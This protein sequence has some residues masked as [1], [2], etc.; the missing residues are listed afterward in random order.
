MA[1]IPTNNVP[2]IYV[3]SLSVPKLNVPKLYVPRMETPGKGTYKKAERKHVKD[4]GDI[5]LGDPIRGTK[6]LK[7]TLQD[8]GYGFYREVPFI[9]RILGLQLLWKERFFEPMSEGEYW[10]AAIN[11]LETLGSSLDI[12]ANP[13]KS[14]MPWAGGGSGEDFLR[15]IGLM[16]GEYRETYQWDTGNGV[17]DF[18]GEVFSDPVNI[19]TFGANSVIKSIVKNPDDIAKTILKDIPDDIVRET[20][21]QTTKNVVKTALRN[22]AELNEE[23]LR[24]YYKHSQSQYDELYNILKGELGDNRKLVQALKQNRISLTP[25]IIKASPKT[26]AAYLMRRAEVEDLTRIFRMTKDLNKR[27][28]ILQAFTNMK[29]SKAYNTLQAWRKIYAGAKEFDEGLLKLA[30]LTTPPIGLVAMIYKVGL[31]PIFQAVWN[32]YTRKLKEVNLKNVLDIQEV[33]DVAT[34]ELE[35]SVNAAYLQTT[36]DW[37]EFFKK[38]NKNIDLQTL[39]KMYREVLLDTSDASFNPALIERKFLI[40]VFDAV[41]ELKYVQDAPAMFRK[42]LK[43]VDYGQI[44]NWKHLKIKDLVKYLDTIETGVAASKLVSKEIYKDGVMRRLYDYMLDIE[45]KA[46]DK[47]ALSLLDADPTTNYYTQSVEDIVLKEEARDEAMQAATAE[48]RK[49]AAMANSY[50]ELKLEDYN[51]EVVLNFL[52]DTVFAGNLNDIVGYLN[53][54][55]SVDYQQYITLLQVLEPL[56]IRLS[57]LD[58]IAPLIKKARVSKNPKAIEKLWAIMIDAAREEPLSE[59][60]AKIA[61]S[62]N[63]R[64]NTKVLRTRDTQQE[65]MKYLEELS[66]SVEDGFRLIDTKV[67]TP[68]NDTGLPP[69]KVFDQDRRR[70]QL[71]K[72]NRPVVLKTENDYDI[73]LTELQEALTRVDSSLRLSDVEAAILSK[74]QTTLDKMAETGVTNLGYGSIDTLDK[75]I[76]VVK[77]ATEIEPKYPTIIE[78]KKLPETDT[79]YAREIIVQ[80]DMTLPEVLA[81]N[82]VQANQV[83]YKGYKET[84]LEELDS[85]FQS[86]TRPFMELLNKSHHITDFYPETMSPSEMLYDF[87][88][89]LKHLQNILSDEF[90]IEDMDKVLL[91]VENFTYYLNNLQTQVD[92]WLNTIKLERIETNGMSVKYSENLRSYLEELQDTLNSYQLLELDKIAQ[93]DFKVMLQSMQD[94]NT[95]LYVLKRNN[96]WQDSFVLDTLDKQLIDNNIYQALKNRNSDLRKNLHHIILQLKNE[97]SI[98]AHLNNLKEVLSTLDAESV[99]G[100][101]LAQLEDTSYV[102]PLQDWI[103]GMFHNVLYKHYNEKITT[104]N[105]EELL[106]VLMDD[107]DTQLNSYGIKSI[108]LKDRKSSFEDLIKKVYSDEAAKYGIYVRFTDAQKEML[109]Q[110]AKE[111]YELQ[112]EFYQQ[113][114]KEKHEEGIWYIEDTIDRISETMRASLLGYLEDMQSVAAENGLKVIS[115]YKSISSNKVTKYMEDLSNGYNKIMEAVLNNKTLMQKNVRVQNIFDISHTIT[116]MS[117]EGINKEAI[118]PLLEK[119][120]SRKQF[121]EN[122]DNLIYLKGSTIRAE[123]EQTFSMVNLENKFLKGATTHEGDMGILATIS[124]ADGKQLRIENMLG[125]MYG[126]QITAL[127][128]SFSDFLNM[129]DFSTATT[130]G[131][132]KVYSIEAMRAFKIYVNNFLP[133]TDGVELAK[134]LKLA[135]RYVEYKP[136]INKTTDQ[137]DR[138]RTNLKQLTQ[139]F[140]K[141][142]QTAVIFKDAAFFDRADPAELYFWDD[143]YSNKSVNKEIA[144]RY[145]GIKKENNYHEFYRKKKSY[146][147]KADYHA[148]PLSI[149]KEYEQTSGLITTPEELVHIQHKTNFEH[150]DIHYK[151]IEQDFRKTIKSLDALNEHSQEV[152]NYVDRDVKALDEIRNFDTLRQDNRFVSELKL[153]KI[154]LEDLRRHGIV[155]EWTKV[156]D[157][158]MDKYLKAKRSEFIVDNLLNYNTTELRSFIDY[159]TE[160]FCFVSVPKGRDPRVLLR[161]T[162]Q[163]L[164][165]AGLKIY[166]INE[167]PGKVYMIRRTDN[168]LRARCHTF[169]NYTFSPGSGLQKLQDVFTN[170]FKN[171]YMYF[172]TDGMRVPPSLMTG[173]LMSN[174]ISRYIRGAKSLKKYFGDETLQKTYLNLDDLGNSNFYVRNIPRPDLV[175]VGELDCHNQV[176]DLAETSNIVSDVPR[177]DLPRT[178]SMADSATVGT[179]VATKMANT[180]HKFAQLIANDDFYIGNPMFKQVFE[181]ASNKEI[182]NFFEQKNFVACILREDPITKRPKLYKYYIRNSKDVAKAVEDKVMLLPYEVYRSGVLV[183]NKHKV[184]SKIINLYKDVVV[185]TYKSIWLSTPGFIMRNFLDSAIYKNLS[186]TDGISGMLANF[187]YEYK[188]A[189]LLDWYDDVYK[190][191][192]DTRSKFGGPAVPNALYVKKVL[193][194]MS[195]SDQQM[196]M[197]ML[198]F[199][200]SGGAAGLTKTVEQ[201]MINYNK[202]LKAGDLNAASETISELL[203]KMTPTSWFNSVNDRVERVSRLGLLLNLIDNGMD[204]SNAFRKVIDTHFDY[205]LADAELGLLS[206]VFWFIT[207]P[208]KNSLY[209]LNEGLTKNPD[210]LKMQ[211]DL[212]EASWVR[213]DM[214]WEDIKNSDYLARNVMTGN[215]RIKFNG[216]DIV[217]KTGSSVFDFFKILFDPFG[218]AKDRL[219]PF[220]SVML[221]QDEPSQLNPL[222]SVSYRIDQIRKGRSLL[223]SVY[224]KLY[225]RNYTQRYR[226]A[227]EPYIRKGKWYFK[228][229]KNY[230]KKPDNMKRMR[231]KFAT[232]RY[233]FNRGKNLHRWLSSTTSIEPHW[234][235]NN[236]R[237]RRTQ[238][239]YN[240]AAKQ[241][242]RIR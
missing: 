186:A 203:Y 189:K 9:N 122:I 241:L 178:M 30:L 222:S 210:M 133:T 18:I 205:Q 128:Q 131:F 96:F 220:L 98:K 77:Q 60:S 198:A 170:A 211:M 110:Q 201:A 72:L 206:D 212:I 10:V 148:N 97:R 144:Q 228:P 41:P 238:G 127:V 24:A 5:F 75:P 232:D 156:K 197:L 7:H 150:M 115:V 82:S 14:L 58:V 91:D 105:I 90:V 204:S 202:L 145:K 176:M 179:V 135:E 147:A 182:K 34:K 117:T 125:V 4:L 69:T 236:Y 46:A 99:R 13:V 49:R 239:K 50:H 199:E 12:L 111:H 217:L 224:T 146:A 151:K 20:T 95:S 192:I 89:K 235:M 65:A 88:N 160:G 116:A 188:A 168:T 233:Y 140:N 6:Q 113:F 57:N 124:D 157:A 85:A 129:Y 130:Y 158:V 149:I 242:K 1:N 123:I 19:A 73:N 138:M 120:L 17:V 230:F 240:R 167:L 40:K 226:I 8:N 100:K 153:S 56:G 175:F 38:V 221:G 219:N 102:K 180:E 59:V 106:D 3:P 195:E 200:R 28:Q 80:R 2:R 53:D 227:K 139:E 81:R 173:D 209:Y 78:T 136:L 11:T 26:S 218:A 15:S 172:H 142:G 33:T 237:Y 35:H 63:A 141:P 171:N 214:T 68:A 207:F 132:D 216:K 39:R 45:L 52:D 51:L 109:T 187:N 183:F 93:P 163:Q 27:D 47:K 155:P 64:Y 165:E 107:V 169:T 94:N 174:D 16:E 54:V 108:L 22:N 44:K 193:Q 121:A 62:T 92:R 177:P 101:W 84:I 48:T 161:H 43:E 25:D 225:D 112:D 231:Y 194:T 119:K 190:K 86:S 37:D 223:P 61:M 23:F 29:Y 114:L 104:D 76:K 83:Y 55:K 134:A 191:I 164:K 185:K 66:H 70:R 143:F 184:D 74:R 152:L 79:D 87:S 118:V 126:D 137:L 32:T 159:E 162:K 21:E 36:K 42:Y 229:R 208:I 234:Y 67:K 154:D 166:E 31:D 196:F 213:D 103:E 181:K 215:L 71:M